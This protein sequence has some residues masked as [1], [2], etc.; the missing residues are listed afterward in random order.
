MSARGQHRGLNIL[1][2]RR[3][4]RREVALGGQHAS[5]ITDH[6]GAAIIAF[7][8]AIVIATGEI[9]ISVGSVCG[10]GALVFLGLAPVV[11]SGLALRRRARVR[12]AYWCFEWCFHRA[13]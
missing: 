8:Q 3:Y 7:G 10:I 6:R 13:A 1:S 4:Y 9:D 11:G 5:A 2:L 12:D